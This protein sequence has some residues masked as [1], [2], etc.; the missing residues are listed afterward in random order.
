VDKHRHE[1]SNIKK[2]TFSTNENLSAHQILHNANQ[3]GFIHTQGLKNKFQHKEF[4]DLLKVNY[5]F[6]IVESWAG[7]EKYEIS[8]YQSV[9]RRRCKKMKYGRNP[10]GLVVYI[11]NIT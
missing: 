7:S 3:I 2:N 6:G 11:K 5:V 4:L 1:K 8:G 10:R 9:N